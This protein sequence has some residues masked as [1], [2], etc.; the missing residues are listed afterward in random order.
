MNTPKIFQLICLLLL[1]LA[2]DGTSEQKRSSTSQVKISIQ[3]RGE[4]SLDL[5]FGVNFEDLTSLNLINLKDKP[6]LTFYDRVTHSI[7]LYTISGGGYVK[8]IELEREGPNGIRSLT[9]FFFH[10]MDSIFVDSSI[11]VYLLDS[12]ANI[13][14][15]KSKG[16]DQRNGLPVIGLD[17]KIYGFDSD[18]HYKEGKV[19][20]EIRSFSRKKDDYERVIYDYKSDSVEEEFIQTGA[21]IRNY[22]D[23]LL[24][25]K[26]IKNRDGLP[27]NILRH[28]VSTDGQAYVGTALSDSLY[29]FERGN[30]EKKLYAGD[31]RLEVA[32]YAAYASRRIIE[33]FEGGMSF[34]DNPRQP[35]YY[36]G[37][38]ISPDGKLLYRLLFHGAKP[39]FIQGEEKPVPNPIGATLIIVDL[40]TNDLTYYDLPVNEVDLD[41]NQFVSDEGIY[42]RVKDQQNEDQVRFKF[43]EVNK[44][45]F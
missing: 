39:K 6:Y 11:G 7:Y 13:V 16:A 22:D 18:S 38:F 21:I 17:S 45:S 29:V 20:M 34:Y 26:M 31:P 40:K 43:F 25:K 32:D 3:Q 19:E 4:L 42:F 1:V 14:D 28:Y 41:K 2:C 9:R 10:T 5:G 15:K 24:E 30:L 23:V 44:S 35:A 37:M 12:E 36:K 33:R 27:P 8:K